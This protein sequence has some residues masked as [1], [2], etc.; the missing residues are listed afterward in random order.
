MPGIEISVV[1]PMRNEATN[2]AELLARLDAVLATIPGDHE[3]VCVND[4]STDGT[5]AA[6]LAARAVDPRIVVVDLSRNFGKELAV[7]AGLD[8]AR[9]RAVVPIDADL[10]D[11][12]ELIAELAAR[13]R[14]G[15]EVVYARRRSRRGESWFKLATARM[16]YSVINRFAEVPIPPNCG[17]YRLLDRRVVDVVRAMPERVRFNKGLFAWVGFRQTVVE[18]DRDPRRDGRTT[19]NYLS[20]WR[21]AIDGITSFSAFPLKIWTYVGVVIALFAFVY[22]SVL[23]LRT[24][25]LGIDVPGYAS[26][27]VAILFLGGCNLIGIGV[28]GEYIGRIFDEVKQRPAY[29]LREVHGP[30]P[31]TGP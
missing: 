2:L 7:T 22:G 8:Q 15:Y 19:W 9:G 5:L 16:F 23:T 21:L 29:V 31:D 28:L 27:I 1:V 24:L 14:D 20:L 11:P 26:L 3:I 12:P 30:D 18:F 25:F 13:W 17:D 4:G 10:Q 6:L